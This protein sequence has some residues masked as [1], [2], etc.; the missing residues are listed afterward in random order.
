[1]QQQGRTGEIHVADFS[2]S[3]TIGDKVEPINQMLN[4]LAQANAEGDETAV[5]TA[6]KGEKD[7]DALGGG[8]IPATNA[9]DIEDFIEKE[10]G[11]SPDIVIGAADYNPT[12]PASGKRD[13]IAQ[14]YDQQV[15]FQ[16]PLF[17]YD[18]QQHSKHHRH[19]QLL[20]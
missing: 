11:S 2:P 8:K 7:L 1:M 14:L 13:V 4:V 17:L 3:S 10:I 15:H 19:D 18:A 6:R 5:V 12:D 9:E 20:L 16:P